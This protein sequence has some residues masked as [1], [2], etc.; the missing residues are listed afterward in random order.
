MRSRSR[1][2]G[3][4]LGLALV[5]SA[6]AFAEAKSWRVLEGVTSVQL[7]K[8]HLAE[9][10]LSEAHVRETAIRHDA[11]PRPDLTDSH[12]F[13]S[14][15]AT[16]LLFEA[17]NGAFRGFAESTPTLLRHQGGL[18]LAARDGSAAPVYFYDFA[19]EIDASDVENPVRIVV[20]GG[21][22]PFEIRSAGFLFDE[23][24]GKLLL[25]LADLVLS[26]SFAKATGHPEL[27]GNWVGTIDLSIDV[28]SAPATGTPVRQ[29]ERVEGEKVAGGT[30]TD[31]KLGELYGLDDV[32]RTGTYPT[33]VLG[34]SAA[35]TSCNVGTADVPWRAPM[36][37]DHPTI[38]L[39]LFRLADDRLEM[40]GQL[41][42]KHGFFALSSSQCTSCQHPS[43][44]SFLGVGCSDT[45]SVSN[46]AS[47]FY[48]GPRTEVNAHSGVWK[49]LGSYFDGNP[50]DC[51]RSFFGG[52]LD[53]VQHR[54]EVAES[55][56]E[57]PGALYY[58]EGCYYVRN[59]VSITNNIGWRQVVP[60]HTSGNSWSFTTQGSGL[61]PNEGQVVDLWGD[62]HDTQTVDVDD[63]LLT[64]ATKVTDLGGGVWHYEYAV[65]NRSSD[66]KIR[67]FSLPI[68]NA[69]IT[70]I[71]F[72]D[73]DMNAAN[74][75]TAVVAGTEIE[76]STGTVGDPE[77]NPLGAQMLFNF[78]FDATEPPQAGTATGDIFK[79][80]AATEVAFAT[81]VPQPSATGIEVVGASLSGELRLH[82]DPNPF[83]ASTR[84][85]FEVPSEAPVNVSV[86][87]V[88]GRVI[89]SL[90][91]GRVMKG[92]GEVAWD[93]NDS[94]GQPVSSGIY[95][96]RV[97]TL[98]EA[99]TIKG[100]LLR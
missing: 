50:V 36:E 74:D 32:G 76:W 58:Y 70:N 23:A 29:G 96:F 88:S 21:E 39:S 100:T 16:P 49:C 28:T 89:R 31:V 99:R 77:A 1:T 44:G 64:L 83:T 66:R 82:S 69:T 4:V 73:I 27:A 5:S 65:Y 41:W 67:T 22:A 81:Q 35:T 8:T 95:F 47:Q 34:L 75:W 40:I 56:L 19:L 60:N 55:E 61:A 26:A 25:P 53:G 37:E 51:Q 87:D 12:E 30:F 43:N 14:V 18:A 92:A 72:H 3:I 91:S 68:G 2:L 48:L 24:A 57:V 85:L 86:L 59:D 90:I 94:T 93:G 54:I 98:G 10:G 42:S 13:A 20:E 71:G 17:E 84:V 7:S 38:G 6:S 52:G 80:R 11:V 62:F 15:P 9:L 33:G 46:N 45:Y 63:G 78:R 97:E 79:I